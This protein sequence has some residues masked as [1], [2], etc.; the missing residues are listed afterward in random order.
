[1]TAQPVTHEDS[2]TLAYTWSGKSDKKCRDCLADS[3]CNEGVYDPL[4][5]A[6]VLANA[7]IMSLRL[8]V[9]GLPEPFV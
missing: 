9:L 2:W 6:G 5:T 4:L 1:M 7:T 3:D 8:R